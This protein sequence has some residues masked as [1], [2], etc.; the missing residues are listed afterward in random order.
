MQKEV[1]KESEETGDALASW[2]VRFVSNF[3]Q[4][5]SILEPFDV[6]LI[7]YLHGS[8]FAQYRFC[9]AAGLMGGAY[10]LKYKRGAM[11]LFIAGTAGT[12]VDIVYGYAYACSKERD[13]H[14][15]AKEKERKAKFDYDVR[16]E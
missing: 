8:L 12:A 6:L 13:V 1:R 7:P 9:V 2:Y 15:E 16:P 4:Y 3:F 5:D 10:G 11:P 14:N